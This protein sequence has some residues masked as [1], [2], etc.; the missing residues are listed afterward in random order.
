MIV[1]RD[2][3]CFAISSIE[4]VIVI[5]FVISIALSSLS[6]ARSAL[7]LSSWNLRLHL[8]VSVCQ[9][10]EQQVGSHLLVLIAGKVSLSA[11]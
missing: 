1:L 4:E 7:S 3:V 8:D 9:S 5:V 10:I 2:N 6:A 11:L